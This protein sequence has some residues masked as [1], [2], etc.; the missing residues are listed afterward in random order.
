M[1][2]GLEARAV[3]GISLGGGGSISFLLGE[4]LRRKWSRNCNYLKESEKK[5]GEK[6]PHFHIPLSSFLTGTKKPNFHS[7]H[8]SSNMK[9]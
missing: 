1:K 4:V 5:T 2:I 6:S 8:L 7:T 3:T 9:C